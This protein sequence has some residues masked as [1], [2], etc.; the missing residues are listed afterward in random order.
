MGFACSTNPSAKFG[1]N[2]ERVP[3]L[4]DKLAIHPI[5]LGFLRK[6]AILAF[7]FGCAF[8]PGRTAIA[9][10]G[11][12]QFHWKTV[13]GAQL[14]IDGKIPLAWNV[15]QPDKKK[16][17]GLVLVLLGHRYLFLDIKAKRAYQVLP[18][19]LHAQAADFESVDLANPAQLI[20]STGWSTRDVG[21]AEILQL[22]LGDYNRMIEVELPHMPDM[23]PFY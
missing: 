7:I 10:S 23:R 6:T 3:L 9:D 8:F 2:F 11:S 14:K 16:Q 20:P 22:T 19:S 17:S 1:Y 5:A 13:T 21:P 12:S 15:Y 18:S 4:G